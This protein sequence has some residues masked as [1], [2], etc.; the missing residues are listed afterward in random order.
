M[1]QQHSLNVKVTRLT[2]QIRSCS[3]SPEPFESFG[4]MLISVR[5]CAYLPTQLCK[6]K[7][8]VTLKGHVAGGDL[9]V[10]HTAVLL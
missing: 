4:Q 9:S 10:P 6:L 8:K 3:T 7:V 2:L 5:R 1:T